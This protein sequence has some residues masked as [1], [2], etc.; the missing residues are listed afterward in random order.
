VPG[1]RPQR[2][3]PV[4]PTLRNPLTFRALVTEGG[5]EQLKLTRA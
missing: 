2:R 4:G 5:A 3:L 1:M